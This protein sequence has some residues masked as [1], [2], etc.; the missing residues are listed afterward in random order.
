MPPKRDAAVKVNPKEY[1][2]IDQANAV[3]DNVPEEVKKQAR[4]EARTL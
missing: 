2:A 4:L 3:K 1:K